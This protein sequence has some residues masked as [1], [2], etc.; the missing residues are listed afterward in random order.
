MSEESFEKMLADVCV[1]RE[2]I[3][4]D[5]GARKNESIGGSIPCPICHKGNLRYSYAGSYNGHVHAA[6]D[7]KVCIQ[8]ME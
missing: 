8:W 1:A 7:T 3:M 5:V 6:C 2:A 4:A